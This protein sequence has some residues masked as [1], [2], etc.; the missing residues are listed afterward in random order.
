MRFS[1]LNGYRAEGFSEAICKCG[2]RFFRLES[3]EDAGVAKRTCTGCGD[4]EFMGD[5]VEFAREA[6]LEEHECVCS[7]RNFELL[8]GVALYTESNDVRWYYIGCH[9]SAC[10]LVGVFAHWKCE[11]GDAT[12]FLAKT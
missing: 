8:S 3:D 6:H 7:S 1:E 2:N 5:S 10:H 12:V 9:C 11:A 4:S